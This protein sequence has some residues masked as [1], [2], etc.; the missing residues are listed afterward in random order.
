MLES[1][2]PSHIASCDLGF[3]LQ[4]SGKAL[5][6]FSIDSSTKPSQITAPTTGLRNAS[7]ALWGSPSFGEVLSRTPSVGPWGHCT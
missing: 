7:P 6:I 4:E 2:F 5:K 3:D 1:S